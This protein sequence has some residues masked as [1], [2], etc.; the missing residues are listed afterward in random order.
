MPIRVEIADDRARFDAFVSSSPLADALQSW[1]W[2]E[3]KRASGWRPLRLMALEAGEVAGT[4]SVLTA[5][6]ARGF[7]PIAYAPR[8]P[9]LDLARP[10]VLAALLRGVREHARPAFAFTCDP[11]VEAGSEGARALA[12]AGL[13]RVD[14]GGFG[15]VQPSTVMVLDLSP[16]L[17]EIFGG[18]KSKWRYNVRL[19]ERRGVEVREA[20][21][22][23]LGVFCDLLRETAR[24]DGFLIRDRSYY[25]AIW[26]NLEP[27]GILRTF[28]AERGGRPI[29]GVMLFVMGDRAIYVYGASSNEER[30]S[31]PNHLL[32][33][34]AIRWAKERGLA[35]Y[36]FRGVSPVRDGKPA[37]ERLAGLGRFKEGFGARTVQYAGQLDLP[38]RPGWY[39]L[40]RVAAPRAIALAK[41]LRRGAAGAGD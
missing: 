3:V 29:A 20:A 25:Q 30:N 40:W 13:R 33:W 24:R 34:H 1:E 11:P 38:L 17:E 26:D 4:C 22:G 19:A 15:G 2:G 41:R 23:D 6:P 35:L 18:F 31:M 36:D 37:D 14:A 8:G 32:Q 27:A 12:A 7:P 9:V 21:R 39:A 5:R 16:P 28:L 10:D